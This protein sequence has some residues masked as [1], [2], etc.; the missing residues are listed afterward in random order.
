MPEVSA[1]SSKQCTREIGKKQLAQTVIERRA[2]GCLEGNPTKMLHTCPLNSVRSISCWYRKARDKKPVTNK[3]GKPHSVNLAVCK[4]CQ[5]REKLQ[6]HATSCRIRTSCI[7][8]V[9][10]MSVTTPY[11]CSALWSPQTATWD[12]TRAH[13]SCTSLF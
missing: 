11:I 13:K 1:H 3:S 5:Q 6:W 4:R 9:R 10:T 2:C 8:C 12:A 7:P